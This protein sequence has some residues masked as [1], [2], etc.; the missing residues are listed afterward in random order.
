[1]RILFYTQFCTP[2]PVFKSVPFARELIRR[3]H[4]VR[5]LTGFPNYPGGKVYPGYRL[6]PL[7]RE[8]LDGVPIT[9]VPLFPSHSPSA[10]ARMAN[11]VSFTLSSAFPLLGGWKPN[12]IYVYN[13]VTLGGVA[14]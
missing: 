3:G 11:Y 10:L 5:I 13:L 9:R 1:M 12:V 6:G 4:E 8:T 14:S 2:E 7:K